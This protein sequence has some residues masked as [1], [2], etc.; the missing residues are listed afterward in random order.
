MD[1]SVMAL[2]Q[3]AQAQPEPEVEKWEVLLEL[4]GVVKLVCLTVVVVVVVAE[5]DPLRGHIH[6]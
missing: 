5:P 4:M 2:K 6:S 3:S 1:Y